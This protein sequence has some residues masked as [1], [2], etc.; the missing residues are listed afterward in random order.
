[1]LAKPEYADWLDSHRALIAEELNVKEVEFTH[2]ADQ[3][4][5]YKVVPNFPA[6]GKKYRALVPGIKAAVTALADPAAARKTLVATGVLSL[7]ID[8][9]TVELTPEEVEIRLEAKPGWSAAPGRSGVVVLSTEL[10][11]ELREEGLIRELIHFVQVERKE[12]NLA[13]EARIAIH[14]ES[15]AEFVAIVQKFASVLRDECLAKSIETHVP[16]SVTPLD[17]DVEGHKV[18]LAILKCV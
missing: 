6:I 13:Y 15:D 18:R 9:Q 1:V 8:G 12:Q 14:I 17:L 5:S 7:T 10:T 16:P 4:V 3:Y 11:P 2:E